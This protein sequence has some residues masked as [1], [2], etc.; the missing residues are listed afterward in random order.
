MPAAA[1]TLPGWVRR[2]AVTARP[3]RRRRGMGLAVSH[4]FCRKRAGFSSDLSEQ[5]AG[6]R[7]GWPGLGRYRMEEKGAERWRD[8]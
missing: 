3:R 7:L 5:V 4:L 8:R 1:S 2:G 6:A